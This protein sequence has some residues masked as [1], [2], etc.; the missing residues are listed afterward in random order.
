M[1]I[2]WIVLLLLIFSQVEAFEGSVVCVHGFIRSYRSMIPMGYALEHEGFEVYLWD[3][4]SRKESIEGH[5]AHLVLVLQSIAKQHPGAPIHFV[6]HSLGGVITQAA[7]NH[8][9]CPQEAKI[10][11]A[12]LLA[13]PAQG[14]SLARS[15]SHLTPVRWFFGGK[16][17]YQLLT[18]TPA[19]M[20]ALGT[21][22]S[23]VEVLV[24]SGTRGNH[25]FFMT[26]NDGKVTVDETRLPTPHT[27]RVFHVSHSWIMTS[28]ECIFETKNFLLRK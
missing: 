15:F 2:S 3:Y 10:G 5:A 17:G 25:F 20:H 18:Y 16:S 6:T 23:S 22:P 19:H 28:R 14:S 11:K 1:K 21:F 7:L 12:V 24:L 27:H 13:P 9:A 8:P 26:P 4:Q